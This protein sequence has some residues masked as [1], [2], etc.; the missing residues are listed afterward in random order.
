[1]AIRTPI[2]RL[3]LS[4]ALAVA[5]AA[6]ALP[7]PARADCTTQTIGGTAFHRCDD[8][9]AGTSQRVGDTTFHHFDGESGT[10][11]RVGET[12]FHHLDGKSGTSQRIGGTTFHHLD[13]VRGTSQRV[14]GT[15]FH[16]FDDGTRGTSQ[17]I[18]GTTFL[19]LQPGRSGEAGRIPLLE[20]G[21]EETAGDAQPGLGFLPRLDPAPRLPALRLPSFDGGDEGGGDF[22]PDFTAPLGGGSGRQGH[23]DLSG[24]DLWD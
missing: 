20:T 21:R 9:T 8:G 13:D 5:L 17:Q 14:G 10:S 18:G 15:T 24:G 16:R 3:I 7:G 23:G 6:F 19:H 22:V 1:M 4:A 12:V 11:L 2:Q